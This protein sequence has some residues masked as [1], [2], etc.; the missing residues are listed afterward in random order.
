MSV[1]KRRIGL[2]TFEFIRKNTDKKLNSDAAKKYFN[3]LL[4]TI[5]NTIFKDKKIIITT[6]NKFYYLVD[7]TNGEMYNILFESAKVGHRPKLVDEETGIKR[8]N[9]KTLH[10]GEAEITHLSINYAAD[11]FIVALEER[12]MGVTIGQIASYLNNFADTLPYKEQCTIKYSIIPYKDFKEHIKDFKRITVGHT[13]INKKTTGTEFLNLANFGDTVRNPIKITY[14]A[15]RNDTIMPKLV[16]YWWDKLTG[17]GKIERIII[18]GDSYDGAKIR[19]D[20]DSLKMKKDVDVKIHS[21]T[22]I[23]DSEDTFKQ[24]N[25]ILQDDIFE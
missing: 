22:G 20:T 24:L 8:D 10:E 3:N 11:T 13:I 5:D 6:S 9:P 25:I 18:E 16:E 12:I 14:K 2:Y 19:L 21:D 23:V 1:S 17:T 15:L 7:F 4:K